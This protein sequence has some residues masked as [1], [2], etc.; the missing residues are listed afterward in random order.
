MGVFYAFFDFLMMSLIAE[1]WDINFSM[2]EIFERPIISSS[3]ANTISFSPV[4]SFNF[5]RISAGITTCPFSPSVV[6]P[7]EF[8]LS[9]FISFLNRLV[10][11]YEMYDISYMT[12]TRCQ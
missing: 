4:F 8:L 11:K 12:Y 2:L 6:T 7:I 1:R 5:L 9:V 3:L 10:S